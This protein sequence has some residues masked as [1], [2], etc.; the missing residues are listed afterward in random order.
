ME[1]TNE[2]NLDDSTLMDELANTSISTESA[3]EEEVDLSSMTPEE[4]AEYYS[5]FEE[6]EEEESEEKEPPKDPKKVEAEKKE[7]KEPKEEPSKETVKV[8]INGEEKEVKIDELVKSYQKGLGADQKFIEA[9]KMRKQAEQ[10]VDML[11]SDP[12]DVLER[13]GLDVEALAEDRLYRKIQFESMTPEEQEA[14][15]NRERL[16]HYEEQERI[17]REQEAYQKFNNQ[18]AFLLEKAIREIQEEVEKHDLPRDNATLKK[19]VNYMNKAVENKISVRISDLVHLV[20][21]DIEKEEKEYLNRYKKKDIDKLLNYLGEDTIKEIQK[22]QVAK[23]KN[24]YVTSTKPA[25]TIGG[26]KGKAPSLDD[27]FDNINKQFG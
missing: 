10:L 4:R 8:K 21:E 20:K 7:I 23:L 5:Q 6:D 18:K 12:L 17:R 1:Q 14:Y 3:N 25:N 13:M 2:T 27:F 19:F 22:K 11:K 9:S 15:I 24:P 16:K 26:K